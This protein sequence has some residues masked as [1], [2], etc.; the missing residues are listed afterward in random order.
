MDT[1][2][3]IE[4]SDREAVWSTFAWTDWW[5]PENLSQDSEIRNGHFHSRS[6]KS[7]CFY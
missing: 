3:D 1:A 2:K 4:E 6:Q 7:Y 5:K